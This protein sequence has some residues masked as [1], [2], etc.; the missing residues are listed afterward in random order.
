MNEA[1]SATND[2]EKQ[3]E[4][5]AAIDKLQQNKPSAGSDVL[6]SLIPESFTVSDIDNLDQ[7]VKNVEND[8]KNISKLVTTLV[9]TTSSVTSGLKD[10]QET[11]VGKDGNGGL[12]NDLNE[13]KKTLAGMNQLLNQYTDPSTPMVKNAKNFK[14]LVTGLQAAAKKLS[15]GSEG[16]LGGVQQVNAGLTQLQK[17][18]EAGITQ[19]AEGSKTLSSNSATLNGGASALSQATGTLA[20]QSG[21][22]NEMADGLDTLGKA[23]ETLNSGAKQLYEGNEQ[24]KSE[25]LDQLKE[26]VDLGVEELETLQSVMD[27]IKAMNKEY[28]SYSGAPEGATVTSRYVF[29]TKEESSK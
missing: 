1:K 23:F 29:R 9:G 14:E 19:V 27:E 7:Y 26:K 15:A 28:A 2:V 24:F 8:Q 4:I 12:K 3:G 21:T 10:A 20:G 11:L 6:A 17:K 22:F 18:S 13:A 25:G 5:Q 16:I